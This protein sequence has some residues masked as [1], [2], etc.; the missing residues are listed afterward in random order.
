MLFGASLAGCS[1][2][3]SSTI[4]TDESG[5]LPTVAQAI[6][7]PTVTPTSTATPIPTDTPT[8][9]PAT[10]T[11]LPPPPN[12]P[13]P[14][15]TG[16]AIR[17]I[18]VLATSTPEQLAVTIDPALEL[19]K[20]DWRPP[21]MPVPIAIHPDDHYWLARPIPSGKRNYDLPWFPY[22]NDVLIE[23]FAPYRVHHGVDFPNEPGTTVL[24]AGDGEVIW[25][26]PLPS[27]RNGVNYYGNT[28]VIQHA[29]QWQGQD[30]FTL[31]AHTLEM[32]V[33]VG[34]KVQTGQL[35]AG[36]GQSGQVSGSHLHFEVRVGENNYW[37]SRNPSLWLAPYEGWGTLAGRFVD[38]TGRMIP[39]A[40]ISVFPI[41]TSFET[42]VR[43][44]RTYMDERLKPD[45]VWN[46]NFVVNDLP[47]GTYEVVILG[48]S[49]PDLTQKYTDRIE[50]LPG[51]TNFLVVQ[52]DYVYV[53]PVPTP[54]T[55][56]ITGTLGI[57]GTVPIT[58]TIDESDSDN[59]E[60]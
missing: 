43:R 28:I 12:T 8:P 51:R 4:T 13:T 5:P 31:Y 56:E 11:A 42:S 40:R 46:E 45:V 22:G 27:P 58:D 50:V 21:Q 23:S 25:A 52:A 39:N 26:G 37:D 53:E 9:I 18:S 1:D 17:P 34:D 44:Q 16:E 7:L 14:L 20:I 3:P 41:E 10:K 24:A 29:W 49:G 38:R 47:A 33:S 6:V 2:A 30:V 54:E 19:E 60:E 32:F 55:S 35:L 36:V 48:E 57:T 59:V 15:P